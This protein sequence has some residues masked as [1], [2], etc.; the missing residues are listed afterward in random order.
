[1]G[2]R[3]QI[4]HSGHHFLNEVNCHDSVVCGANRERNRGVGSREQ[5]FQ[6]W[7]MRGIVV[8]L[9]Y[10]ML[11]PYG[12]KYRGGQQGTNISGRAF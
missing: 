3:E 1:V 6:R 9:L 10:S 5:I 12:G 11:C 8:I 2:S 4:F 7:G